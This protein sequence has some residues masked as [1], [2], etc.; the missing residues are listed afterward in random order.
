M[1]FGGIPSEAEKS[2]FLFSPCNKIRV[3]SKKLYSLRVGLPSDQHLE[4]SAVHKWFWSELI[5]SVLGWKKDKSINLDK[6]LFTNQQKLLRQGLSCSV[7]ICW[8]WAFPLEWDW[9]CDVEKLCCEFLQK[10]YTLTSF[11]A[12]FQQVETRFSSPTCSPAVGVPALEMHLIWI[13]SF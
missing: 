13:P 6:L 2:E 8:L 5:S 12:L 3:L 10:V 9:H 7:F 4:S 1:L 11:P